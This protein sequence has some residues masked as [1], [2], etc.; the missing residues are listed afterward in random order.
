MRVRRNRNEKSPQVLHYKRGA[1]AVEKPEL[2]GSQARR[3][4][5]Y[6]SAEDRHAPPRPAPPPPRPPREGGREN[7]DG[8]SGIAILG[9]RQ[10]DTRLWVSE[11]MRFPLS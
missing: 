6:L 4:N 7:P 1:A 11:A 3:A 10:D 2:R 5:S 9:G 8:G